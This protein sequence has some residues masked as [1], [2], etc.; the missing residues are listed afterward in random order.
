[1]NNSNLRDG[2]NHQEL[3]KL[4]QELSSEVRGLKRKF[5]NVVKKFRKSYLEK[6]DETRISTASTRW[7]GEGEIHFGSQG[8]EG[9]RW[10]WNKD[11]GTGNKNSGSKNTEAG[12]TASGRTNKGGGGGKKK[13]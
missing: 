2:N 11:A 13:I 1:M 8:R 4:I 12:S 6:N 9:R 7:L 5:E 10:S 3:M